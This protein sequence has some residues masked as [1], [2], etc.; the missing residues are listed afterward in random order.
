[1]EANAG[2]DATVVRNDFDSAPIFREI[3]DVEDT[4][5][6]KFVRIPKFY[7]R[8]TEGVDY[9]TWQISKRQYPGFYL[10]Q[11]FWDFTNNRELPYFDFGKYQASKAATKLQ[12]VSGAY[13]LMNDT[14]VNFRTYAQNNNA[15]GLLGYQQLDIH[16]IDVLQTLFYVEFATLNSQAIM[17]GYTNGQYSAS[18]VATVA[19]NGTNRIIIA[20]AYAALFKVG[21][22]ISIGTSL[23]GN[24]ICYN[25]TITSIDVYDAS[26]K[27]ITF[28]GATENIALGNIVYNSGRKSGACDAVVA[29][30]GVLTANNGL[31]PCKYRGIENPFGN[32]WQWVDGLNITDRQA[33]ICKNP[34]NYASNVFASPYE[35]LSYV[36]ASAGGYPTAMGY[37]ANYPF[38]QLPSTVG[39]DSS[40]YYSDYYFQGTGQRGA[41]FGGGWEKQ[42]YAGFRAGLCLNATSSTYSGPPA[43]GFLKNLFSG[44]LGA[45]SPH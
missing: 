16:A 5:G 38:A 20:N 19:E 44:G 45:A 6:N 34:A 36:N 18:H 12:S 37:D 43:G 41:R 32:M 8:K 9:K 30:S 21:Q 33:W 22:A 7:I 10:P 26:N 39:V 25:R 31:Y 29:T 1:M 17:L 4:L 14:I 27:A 3:V 11:C 24:Q 23:G 2:V 42:S 13:P 35:Q 15:D 40:H 28:D